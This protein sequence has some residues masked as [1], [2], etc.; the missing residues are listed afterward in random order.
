MCSGGGL[1]AQG[2]QKGL[3]TASESRIARLPSP[4]DELASGVTTSGIVGSCTGARVTAARAYSFSSSETPIPLV[5][6]HL[7]HIHYSVPGSPSTDSPFDFNLSW[8]DKESCS[9]ARKNT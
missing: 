5:L 7:V 8:L 3:K 6:Y 2:G 1:H 4:S 9:Q